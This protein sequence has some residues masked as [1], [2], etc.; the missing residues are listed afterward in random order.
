MS[1]HAAESW[2][3]FLPMLDMLAD[4]SIG[5]G[6]EHAQKGL[7]SV[8]ETLKHFESLRHH[9]VLLYMAE[10]RAPYRKVIDDGDILVIYDMLHRL[11]ALEQ[12]DLIINTSGGSVTAVRKLLHLLHEVVSH[13]TI[14]VPYKAHSAGTLLCLGAHDVVLTSMAE[15][16]PIDPHIEGMQRG[17]HTMFSSEDIATFRTMA[18]DWFGVQGEDDAITLLRLFCD[19]M[20]PPS[21]AHFFRAEHLVRQIAQEAVCFQLPDASVDTHQSIVEQ[22]L[23]GYHDH[24]YPLTR[25]DLTRLGLHITAPSVEEERLL[26][27]IW[28]HSRRYLDRFQQSSEG[29][30]VNGLV[31]S[32]HFCARHRVQVSAPLPPGHQQEAIVAPLFHLSQW[33]VSQP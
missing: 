3:P 13:L 10:D 28:A 20:F 24:L 25:I 5:D 11:G 2:S 29:T 16:S 9:P 8:I 22:L 30:P 7:A 21:L 19:Q 12:L 1:Q 18:R 6:P 32:S 17:K 27:S 33:E 14:L 4:S 26:W 23:T 15:L 31:L